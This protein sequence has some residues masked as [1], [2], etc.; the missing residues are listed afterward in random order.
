M[1]FALMP[2]ASV[3][4]SAF[5]VSM[6]RSGRVGSRLHLSPLVLVV[7]VVKVLSSTFGKSGLTCTSACC[8]RARVMPVVHMGVLT[9]VDASH[10][11]AGLRAGTCAWLVMLSV[12]PEYRLLCR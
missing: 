3:R 4:Y 11:A 9:T 10:C 1:A 2:E 8:R 12:I 6:A 5:K 7:E